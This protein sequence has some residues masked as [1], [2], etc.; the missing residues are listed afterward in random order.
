MNRFSTRTFDMAKKRRRNLFQKSIQAGSLT[1][2]HVDFRRRNEEVTE[3][4]HGD[5]WLEMGFPS[6][7]DVA[8][9]KGLCNQIVSFPGRRGVGIVCSGHR[10]W[11]TGTRYAIIPLMALPLRETVE[12][13]DTVASWAFE[14]APRCTPCPVGWEYNILCY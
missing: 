14:Q 9:L 2:S 1:N 8:W 10:A 11:G 7:G 5:L 6:M 4:Y 12:M 3:E 13:E